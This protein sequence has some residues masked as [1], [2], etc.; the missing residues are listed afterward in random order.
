MIVKIINRY[1]IE[2]EVTLEQAQ[3]FVRAWD[4]KRTDIY[5]INEKEEVKEEVK[6]SK[7]KKTI[8]K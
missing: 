5:D 3:A 2:F 4:I 7:P 6:T 1:W 8:N